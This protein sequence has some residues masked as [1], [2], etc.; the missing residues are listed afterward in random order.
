L[1][2]L[3]IKKARGSSRASSG[4]AARSGQ[5][6]ISSGQGIRT[7]PEPL[8]PETITTQRL[9]VGNLS[10]DTTESDLYDAFTRYG[11]VKNVE[12]I[13]DRRTQRSKG[14][15]F[16]EMETMA[17]ARKAAAAMHRIEFMGRTIVVGGAKADPASAP[18]QM[19]NEGSNNGSPSA[20]GAGATP[21]PLQQGK[22]VPAVEET[23]Q[24]ISATEAPASPCDIA[25]SEENQGRPS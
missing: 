22:Q 17:D 23:S 16:V 3:G 11:V 2:F 6:S 10:Y 18:A 8:N 15:G 21:E 1:S 13:I 7:E 5:V 14:F 20:N 25:S 12:V 4:D 9:Y 24:E 19:A